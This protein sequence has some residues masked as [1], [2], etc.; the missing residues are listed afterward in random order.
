MM[1]T[2][3]LWA[4]TALASVVEVSAQSCPAANVQVAHSGTP[5]GETKNVNGIQTY[6]SYPPDK[7]TDHAIL[8]MLDAF[9]LPLA[10]NRLLADSMARAGYLVVVPDYFAGEPAPVD[11]A[12]PGAFD[13]STWINRHSAEQVDPILENT[14]KYMKSTLG[15]KKIGAV[16]Y[17]FGG[18]Y[19]G[20]FLAK[21]KGLDAGFMAHPTLLSAPEAQAIAGPVSVGAAET[22]TQFPPEKRH[23]T[24]GIFQKSK[25]PYQVTLYGGVSH[26]FAVRANISNPIEK[27]AKEEAFLQAIR[28]FDTWIKK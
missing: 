26:G 16:G 24:E 19:V 5:V 25:I 12:K 1:S 7:K 11:L 20:R 14:I 9:G 18:R 28:W 3:L 21:G 27:Y 15:V 10:E 6:I 17:C 4:L 2:K 8:Y 13:F 22:D 23:E